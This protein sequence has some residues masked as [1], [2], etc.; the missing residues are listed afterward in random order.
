MRNLD[1]PTDV[2]RRC[3][4]V[5]IAQPAIRVRET[6]TVTRPERSTGALE[7][8]TT[9]A[10]KRPED[11]APEDLQAYVI[12][13]IEQRFG[14]FPKEP[15]RIASTFRAFC[16]RFGKMAGPIAVVAFE[17]YQGKWKGAPVSWQ[18]FCKNSDPYFSQEILARLQQT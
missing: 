16:G 10:G 7:T 11:W 15:A 14:P 5:H 9:Y 6:L 13:Q 17:T 2:A 12:S 3:G 8:R 18:R 1:T 4:E